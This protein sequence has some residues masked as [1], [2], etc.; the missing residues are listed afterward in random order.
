MNI[1][2]QKKLKKLKVRLRRLQLMHN[3]E[4]HSMSDPRG[5]VAKAVGVAQEVNPRILRV[6][7]NIE[8][9][10]K[11]IKQLDHNFEN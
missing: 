1:F 9:L 5:K 7:V 11:K 4:L 8:K 6:R 2:K 3:N 10:I